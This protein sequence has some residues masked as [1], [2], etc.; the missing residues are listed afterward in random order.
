MN[1]RKPSKRWRR[2]GGMRSWRPTC[3]RKPSTGF[4]GPD[5]CRCGQDA[6]QMLVGGGHVRGCGGG[7]RLGGRRTC[8]GWGA[9]TKVTPPWQPR[10]AAMNASKQPAGRQS[11]ALFWSF[12]WVRAVK[13]GAAPQGGCCAARGVHATTSVT[14]VLQTAARGCLRLWPMCTGKVTRVPRKTD[15]V[16]V[17]VLYLVLDARDGA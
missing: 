2:V 6:R 1:A 11:V 5:C 12:C 8:R 7:G 14:F 10:W 17:S 9:G 13:G 4:K 15:A 16:A 3:C